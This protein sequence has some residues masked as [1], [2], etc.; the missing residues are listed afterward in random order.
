ML[1]NIN[2]KTDTEL[3]KQADSLFADLRMNMTTVLNIF[4]R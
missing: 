4:M 1:A 2:I 3:K